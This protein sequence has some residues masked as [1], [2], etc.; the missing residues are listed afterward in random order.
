V[1]IVVKFVV[2][3]MTRLRARSLRQLYPIAAAPTSRRATPTP[4]AIRT[5]AKSSG[6]GCRSRRRTA[7]ARTVWIPIGAGSWDGSGGSSWVDVGRILRV[8][9][10]GMRR[11]AAAL[12][13]DRFELVAGRLR[14]RYGRL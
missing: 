1:V 12:D 2:R 5:R 11:K 10:Q 6:L 14:D 7:V 8:H 4:T 3:R 13:R 9:P